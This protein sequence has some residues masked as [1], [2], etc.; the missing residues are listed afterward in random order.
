MNRF[1]GIGLMM[2][3]LNAASL[4]AQQPPPAA[5]IGPP[6]TP[7]PKRPPQAKTQ[8]E[9]ADYNA[10]Q[11]LA[12]GAAEEKAADDFAARYPDSELRAYLYLKAMHDYQNENNPAKIMAMGEK[13]LSLDPD[14]SIALVLTA[15]VLSDSLSDA[16]LDREQKISEIRRNANHAL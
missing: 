15:T 5:R 16:D 1:F 6:A 12:G 7:S 10:A 9:Y 11:A 4:G 13:T 8:A 14:N 2:L 3:A